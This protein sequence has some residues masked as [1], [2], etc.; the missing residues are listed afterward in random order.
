MSY[1]VV[2]KDAQTPTLN[3]DAA[4]PTLWSV[5]LKGGQYRKKEKIGCFSLLNGLLKER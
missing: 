3:L 2:M 1:D 5:V 4:F